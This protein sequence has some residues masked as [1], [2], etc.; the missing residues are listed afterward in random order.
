[1]DGLT[2]NTT[3]ENSS[4]IAGGKAAY[5]VIVVD[6]WVDMMVRVLKSPIDYSSSLTEI[7]SKVAERGGITG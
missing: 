2:L 5:V 3:I 7:E 6:R 1:M 4:I